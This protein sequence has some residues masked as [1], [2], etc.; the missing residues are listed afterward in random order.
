MERGPVD[1]MIERWERE[2]PDLDSSSL[3]VV[4]RVTRLARALDDVAEDEL[5]SLAWSARGSGAPS[6]T[7]P[8]PLCASST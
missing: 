7:T 1:V 2:R 4:A 3:A 5:V 6:T 8:R